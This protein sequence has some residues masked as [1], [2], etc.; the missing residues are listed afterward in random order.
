RVEVDKNSDGSVECA[1]DITIYVNPACTPDC[2]GDLCGQSDGCG[3]FC[4]DDDNDAPDPPTLTS[5][6]DGAIVEPTHSGGN[7]IIPLVVQ[8]QADG[9][10]HS[11]FT[12]IEV[13][14]VGTSCAHARARCVTVATQT[15]TT[16]NFT[17]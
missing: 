6:A 16:Y 3:G 1:R 17:I 8:P 13:Y 2:S 4:A 14:P 15:P 7:S 11:E 10:Q 9:T 5:P 12:Q